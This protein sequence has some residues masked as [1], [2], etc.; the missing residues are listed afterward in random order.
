MPKAKHLHGVGSGQV[1][2]RVGRMRSG[3]IRVQK[4]TRVRL[5]WFGAVVNVL[6]I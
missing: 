2:L 5:C 4:V 3:R 1:G 6:Q